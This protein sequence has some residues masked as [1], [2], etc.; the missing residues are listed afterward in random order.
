[1][2][3]NSWQCV[4]KKGEMQVGDRIL[5]LEID[6][7]IPAKDK[8]FAFLADAGC[9]RTMNGK[10][11]Y[12]L[13]TVKRKKQISQG[14]ALPLT[15][16]PE[17]ANCKSGYDVTEKLGVTI[18]DRQPP[19]VGR[20]GFLMGRAAGKFPGFIRKTDQERIQSMPRSLLE[21]IQDHPFEIT[22]KMDGTSCSMYYN[23]GKFGVCSRNLELRDPNIRDPFFV[24]VWNRIKKVFGYDSRPSHFIDNSVY[25]DMEKRYGIRD[26]LTEYCKATGRNLALQG[27]ICGPG[28]QANRENLDQRG[29]FIFDIWD[30]NNQ[31]YLLSDERKRVVEALNQ[32]TLRQHIVS[33]LECV[34]ELQEVQRDKVPEYP[35]DYLEGIDAAIPD[36]LAMA[37]G[38]GLCCE[39]REG[40]V[41]KSKK[42]ANFSFK[43]ISNAYLLKNEL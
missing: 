27:E 1:M 16:F 15:D 35:L 23:N 37:D 33:P 17:F 25:W 19:R 32:V 43:V 39:R 14:L 20:F 6:S 12:R 9:T 28:I 8:R 41:F 2:K 3:E 13:R 30:I 11:V 10:R 31:W 21:R 26:R 38:R 42:D 36:I 5:Y 29:Y 4:I 7:A 18:Y 22:I 34:P 40:L 24:R